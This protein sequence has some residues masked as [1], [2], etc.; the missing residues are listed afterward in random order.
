M[1]LVSSTMLPLGTPL[2]QFSLLNTVNDSTVSHSDYEGRGV[3]VM[4]ICNHC[5]Y[6]IH[7]RG[8]LAT[9][10]YEYAGSD[11]S[12]VAISSN[13]V[14]S[15][16]QD[17]PE[18]MKKE[19]ASAGYSFPYLYDEDQSV[20]REFGAT[21][22]PDFFL[23]DKEHKLV[24]RGRFDASSPGNSNT[25]DGAELRA[26]MQALIKGDNPAKEQNPS[27]GCSIKW[28]T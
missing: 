24:Y 27:I 9:L 1:A 18:M 26:A 16:P 28:R 23:F 14:T 21:C 19:A 5:P 10:G 7:L 25:V 2:P 11:I 6:V 12:I 20:A 15:H 3:L 13:D 8:A 17:G 4:F 22:T